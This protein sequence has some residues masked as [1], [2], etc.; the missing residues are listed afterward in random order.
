MGKRPWRCGAVDGLC[1]PSERSVP[2]GGAD[3]APPYAD[4]AKPCCRLRE[5]V[6]RSRSV[7]YCPASKGGAGAPGEWQLA[8]RLRRVAIYKDC[9]AATEGTFCRFLRGICRGGAVREGVSRKWAAAR[10]DTN[11]GWPPASE[12]STTMAKNC[13]VLGQKSATFLPTA[14]AFPAGGILLCANIHKL[15]DLSTTMICK[16][17]FLD[18]V[19]RRDDGF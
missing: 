1:Q 18:I 13:T 12:N 14:A 16:I 7:H 10:R 15:C 2:S 6:C 3:C 4:C 17:G 11:V 5:T 19:K 9:S 8:F